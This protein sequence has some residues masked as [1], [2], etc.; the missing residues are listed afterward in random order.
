M[1][2]WSESFMWNLGEPELLRV[3][4]KRVRPKVFKKSPWQH[5]ASINDPLTCHPPNAPLISTMLRLRT[6]SCRTAEKLNTETEAEV[7]ALD[8]QRF[9]LLPVRRQVAFQNQSSSMPTAL[10]L[11]TSSKSHFTIQ[12]SLQNVLS[13]KTGHQKH[14]PRIAQLW[15]FAWNMFCFCGIHWKAA[16]GKMASNAACIW[17][18]LFFYRVDFLKRSHVLWPCW[19]TTNPLDTRCHPEKESPL[20][21]KCWLKQHCMHF[22]TFVDCP[23]DFPKTEMFLKQKKKPLGGDEKRLSDLVWNYQTPWE[24]NR[25]TPERWYKA[26]FGNYL[27]AP[28]KK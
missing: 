8:D 10:S 20:Q 4:P 28:C 9:R 18:H 26:P 13:H 14:V 11:W 15:V 19:L 17:E 25:E 22:L 7:W 6:Y 2:P 16:R 21:Q 23:V 27:Q 24:M 12:H 1:E 3:R 5:W